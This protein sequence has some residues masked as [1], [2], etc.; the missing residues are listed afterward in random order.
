MSH[1]VFPLYIQQLL[2]NYQ[3]EEVWGKAQITTMP[4]FLEEY[5]LH[6][7]YFEGMWYDSYGMG[8]VVFRLDHIWF[9]EWSKTPKHAVDVVR[10]A[11]LCVFLNPFFQMIVSGQDYATDKTIGVVTS[12]YVEDH[13]KMEWLDFLLKQCGVA[14]NTTDYVLDSRLCRTKIEGIYTNNT[15]LFHGEIVRTWC[16]DFEGKLVRLPGLKD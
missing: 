1:G 7:S 14:E 10:V 5:T 6:D 16:F 4:A 2:F 8:F 11:Y 13:E 12:Q 3:D 9:A 15:Y